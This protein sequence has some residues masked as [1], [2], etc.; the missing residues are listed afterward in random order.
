MEKFTR[1]SHIV[2]VM[3][4][5]KILKIHEKNYHLISQIVKTLLVNKNTK[6]P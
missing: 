1:I 3:N 2:N 5:P 4:K 6:L